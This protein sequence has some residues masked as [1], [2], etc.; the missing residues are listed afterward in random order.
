ML[1]LFSF[2]CC[3]QTFPPGCP[4]TTIC[5]NRPKPKAGSV[6]PLILLPDFPLSVY[7]AF[8][9]TCFRSLGPSGAFL[10]GLPLVSGTFSGPRPLCFF[11]RVQASFLLVYV[12]PAFPPHC[13]G[14]TQMSR[15]SHGL[16]SEFSWTLCLFLTLSPVVPEL[17]LHS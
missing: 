15:C 6:S 5:L 16:T 1:L 2:A 7:K 13:P 3:A 14:L 10:W 17:L 8:I 4:I 11:S 9:Q 12:V